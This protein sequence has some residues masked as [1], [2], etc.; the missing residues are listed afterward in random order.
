MAKRIILWLFVLFVIGFTNCFSQGGVG[1]NNTGAMPDP[2]AILDVNSTV[3]GL[4]FPR[5]TTIERNAITSPANSLLIFNI[6]TECFEAYRTS[7]SSWVAFGCIGCSVPSAVTASAGPNPICEGSTLTLTGGAI[8]ATDWSWTGPNSFTSTVQNP[9]LASI[10]TPGAGVYTLAAGNACG[11]S[12]PAN[13]ASV[14]VSAEPTTANAGS[15]INPACGVTT[16]TLAGNTPTIG[17]GNWSVIS[18]TATI[19]TPS[20]PTSGV[21]G[22]AAAGTATLRWTISN[23]P[24]AASS[25]D[26][27]ITTT[28]C[29]PPT[30]VCASN[31]FTDARDGKQYSAVTIGS[32]IWMCENLAYLPSV[33]G[34]A[35][36]SSSVAYYYVYGYNGTNVATA[37]ATSNYTNYGVLYN[38]TAAM[39]GAGSSNSNPSGVQGICPAGWHLPSDAELCV[40]ENAVEAGTDAGC[41]TLGFRGTATGGKMKRTGTTRWTAPNTGATNASG[42]TGIGGGIRSN[43]G[44][45]SFM[46]TAGYIWSTRQSSSTQSWYRLLLNTSAQ[47]IRNNT[48]KASGHSVRCVKD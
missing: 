18:G 21:T 34:S 29:A 20:S 25:D 11:W 4:L 5:M 17:T 42:F 40:L 33:V 31:W 14:V 7:S 41:S 47:S 27:V 45:F 10:T 43:A 9:T 24:C 12:A 36:G 3:S 30:N 35:T 26:V 16:A 19:T 38:W 32:Q 8:G 39:N 22:L 2:S 1:I 15:S 48:N 46:G 44:A 37:K 13:S 28:S 23:A 6:T